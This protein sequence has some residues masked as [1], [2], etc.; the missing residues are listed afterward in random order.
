MHRLIKTIGLGVV[1]LVMIFGLGV[2]LPTVNAGESR[3]ITVVGEAEVKVVPDE[4][5]LTMAVETSDPDLTE[6]KKANDARVRKVIG[7]TKQYG[8]EE[9]LVQTG[10]L[11]IEPRYRDSYEKREFLGYFV[12]KRIIVQLKDLNKFEDLLSSVLA[13]GVNYIEGIQFRRSDLERYKEQAQAEAVQAAR[14]KAARLAAEL[15]QKLGEPYLI[16]EA[17]VEA[18]PVG[19]VRNQSFKVYDVMQ[20]MATETL[21]P[22]E[23]CVR[24]AFTVSFTLE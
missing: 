4:V 15:G 1:L 5:V 9:K 11:S 22:G 7:L 24:S 16:Q 19:A 2:M 3:L 10:Q 14:A 17:G 8:I 12:R 6:A 18:Y 23:L 21:A 13:D 20:E